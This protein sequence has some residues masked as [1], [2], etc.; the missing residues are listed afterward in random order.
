[1][2]YYTAVSCCASVFLSVS[3]IPE[4]SHRIAKT[5]ILPALEAA[6]AI[7]ASI[8]SATYVVNTGAASATSLGA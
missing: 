2:Q 5:R 1:M 4:T 3:S 8:V 6:P 7:N